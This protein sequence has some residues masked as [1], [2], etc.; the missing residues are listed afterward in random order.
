MGN[1][2]SGALASNTHEDTTIHP[3]SVPWKDFLARLRNE[4][5][6]WLRSSEAMRTMRTFLVTTA[7]ASLPVHSFS[8]NLKDQQGSMVMFAIKHDALMWIVWMEIFALVRDENDK[9]AV[10]EKTIEDLPYPEINRFAPGKLAYINYTEP[11]IMDLSKR[12]E[13]LEEFSTKKIETSK[14]RSDMLKK[15]IG[16]VQG[17]LL[18]LPIDSLEMVQRFVLERDP[19]N[20]MIQNALRYNE[21]SLDVWSRAIVASDNDYLRK[22]FLGANFTDPIMGG[23]LTEAQKEHVNDAARDLDGTYGALTGDQVN[24]ILDSK[25]IID[26]DIVDIYGNFMNE[27][28]R[29]EVYTGTK[30]YGQI[31]KTSTRTRSTIDIQFESGKT[32]YIIPVSLIGGLNARL[33]LAV[34]DQERFQIRVYDSQNDTKI[35]RQIKTVLFRWMGIENND[36]KT[37]RWIISRMNN[38]PVSTNKSNYIIMLLKYIEYELAAQVIAG[39]D[40]KD[41]P[42]FRYVIAYKLLTREYTLPQYIDTTDVDRGKARRKILQLIK[43][44]YKVVQFKGEKTERKRMEELISASCK[45]GS[46]STLSPDVEIDLDQDVFRPIE[47]AETQG[48]YFKMM[49]VQ[50]KDNYTPV[51]VMLFSNVRETDNEPEHGDLDLICVAPRAEGWLS[52]LLI[53]YVLLRLELFRDSK[54]V[55]LNVA[56]GDRNQRAIKFYEKFGFRYDSKQNTDGYTYYMTVPRRGD[57]FLSFSNLH[58][59]LARWP[60]VYNKIVQP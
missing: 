25:R 49:A 17:S 54:Y 14:E 47:L 24:V 2:Y 57:G 13:F 22:Q 18:S 53:A 48:G 7:Y 1:T 4:P 35:I 5:I 36:K 37:N 33:V 10:M 46:V 38:V 52:R 11:P 60:D 28:H 9:Y 50:E 8:D 56:A 39:W 27:I 32:R 16:Y 59:S 51:G 12:K 45:K 19:G 23:Y 21:V 20:K 30:F 41:V 29:D 3:D 55:I 6:E 44:W 31:S 34:L 40:E 26:D 15:L 58:A 42:R 43:D